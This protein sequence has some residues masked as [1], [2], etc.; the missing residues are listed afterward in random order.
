MAFEEYEEIN[1]NYQGL[2]ITYNNKRYRV[3]RINRSRNV[4]LEQ[5]FYE[6][7]G[8]IVVSGRGELIS[9][10]DFERALFFTL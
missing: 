8:Y 7:N 6:N 2:A 9:F 3:K 1:K 4:F 10:Q 5:I